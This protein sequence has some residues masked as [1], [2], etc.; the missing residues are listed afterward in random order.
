MEK[1]NK[2]T[3]P[4]ATEEKP[5]GIE[6]EKS[7]L[8]SILKRLDDKDSEIELL[9]RSVGRYE[10]EKAEAGIAK[11]AGVATAKLLVFKGKVVVSWKMTRNNYLYNPVNPNVAYGE[12]LK[13]KFTYADGTESEEVPYV[14][15]I[16][17]TNRVV[18]EKVG[19]DGDKWIVSLNGQNVPVN[20]EYL[21]P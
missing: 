3:T 10:L 5:K 2:V 14:D 20:I 16:R 7:V 21:N 11:P 9:R 4:Q 15:F 12:E 17:T 8:E 13:I 6:V 1:D 18:V 19:Q